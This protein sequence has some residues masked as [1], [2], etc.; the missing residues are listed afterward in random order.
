MVES[1][2]MAV[3]RQPPWVVRSITKATH[4]CLGITYSDLGLTVTSNIEQLAPAR[5]SLQKRGLLRQQGPYE[6]L[7]KQNR[8]EGRGKVCRNE[9]VIAASSCREGSQQKTFQWRI[10]YLI[11]FLIIQRKPKAKSIGKNKKKTH[12]TQKN[13]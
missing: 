4:C 3:K 12:Q 13:V 1:V 2:V 6:R 5:Q 10:M 8:A 7:N 11:I 9:S